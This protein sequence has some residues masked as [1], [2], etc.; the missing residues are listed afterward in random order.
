MGDFTKGRVVAATL[1]ALMAVNYFR[2]NAGMGRKYTNRKLC[3]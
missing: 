3:R 1:T 2:Y